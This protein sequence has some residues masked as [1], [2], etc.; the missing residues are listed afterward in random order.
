MDC[1]SGYG[2]EV[3]TGTA[4]AAIATWRSGN[5]EVVVLQ[6]EVSKGHPFSQKPEFD[7]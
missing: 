4:A 6:P 2:P 3:T 1:T 5:R 7:E